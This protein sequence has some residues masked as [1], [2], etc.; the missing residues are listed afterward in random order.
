VSDTA[1]CIG[2]SVTLHAS[3]AGNISWYPNPLPSTAL[4]LGNTFTPPSLTS[5]ATY[6]V[7]TRDSVCRSPFVPV[8]VAVN[9][10]DDSIPNV[11]T[12]N[13]DGLNDWFIFPFSFGKCFEA[14]IYN[15]WGNLIYEWSN[16]LNGWNGKTK[17]GSLA[18]DGVYYY[19]LNY[20]DSYSK[21]H[22]AH[23]Y[24]ELIR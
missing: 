8:T 13:G 6:Y 1:I 3:G 16:P 17:S 2:Q 14:K 19:I 4:A 18:S 22:T 9:D 11:F 5:T 15:R 10:C 21:S 24:V 20:C 12:P 23:G 7:S